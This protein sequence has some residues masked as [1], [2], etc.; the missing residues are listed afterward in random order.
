M[1]EILMGII[2]SVISGEYSEVYFKQDSMRVA[3]ESEWVK[4]SEWRKIEIVKDTLYFETF[5]EWRDN[6]KAEIKYVGLNKIELRI[7]ETDNK[8]ELKP[9]SENLNFDKSNEFWDGFKSRMNNKKC[10]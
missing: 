5:G 2:L 3:S 9:I 1:T 6:S 8:L 10:K 4:L 7:L